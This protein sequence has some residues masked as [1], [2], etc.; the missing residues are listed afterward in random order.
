MKDERIK[1]GC[2]IIGCPSYIDLMEYRLGKAGYSVEPPYLPKS[3]RRILERDD[4]GSIL[5]ST[6]AMPEPLRRKQILVLSGGD[7]PLV[8][9]NA[10]KAF[11]SV[12][13][14]QSNDIQVKTYP[15][16]GHDYTPIMRKD[17][18]QWIKQLL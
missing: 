12:L 16:V 6:K 13:Q 15:G 3:F 7:D 10:S 8:P 4:P 1:W 11:I 18:I 2:S 9:S 14:E 17:F 5:R